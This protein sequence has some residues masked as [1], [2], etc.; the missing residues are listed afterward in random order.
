MVKSDIY[1]KLWFS[2]F[3]PPFTVRGAVAV[4]RDKT[5]KFDDDELDIKGTKILTLTFFSLKFKIQSNWFLMKDFI[6]NWIGSKSKNKVAP[7]LIN[8]AN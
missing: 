8:F 3:H 5:K 1:P 7:L 6:E 2:Y 4:S